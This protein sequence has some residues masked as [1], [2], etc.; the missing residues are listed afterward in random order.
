MLLRYFIKAGPSTEGGK[1]L[2]NNKKGATRM[3]SFRRSATA[4]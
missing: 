4:S 2:G 1:D 3:R